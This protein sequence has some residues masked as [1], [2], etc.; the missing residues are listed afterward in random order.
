MSG[1]T[2]TRARQ[3][4][5]ESNSFSSLSQKGFLKTSWKVS[6]SRRARS[7]RATLP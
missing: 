4:G 6:E 7:V 1:R 3:K 5:S 2:M